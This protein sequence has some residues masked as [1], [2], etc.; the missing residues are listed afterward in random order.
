MI[1][2]A[3]VAVAIALFALALYDD[4]NARL[5][6]GSPSALWNRIARLLRRTPADNWDE[7]LVGF[8]REA[9]GLLRRRWPALTLTTL[10][11][12]LTVFLVLLVAL[13]AVG[14]PAHGRELGRGVRLLGAGT[15]HHDD[16][17]HARRDSESWSS[18]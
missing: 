4:G 8:R 2:S 18:A 17:D 3:A 10:A 7:R 12:H 15:G 6:G 16:P 13:R 9:V 14:V 1:G 5:V 11:G